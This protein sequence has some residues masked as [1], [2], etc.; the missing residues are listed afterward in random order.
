MRKYGIDCLVR[1][2]QCP[3]GWKR[4]GGSCYFV[5]NQTDT[6]SDANLT[7]KRRQIDHSSLIQIRSAIELVYA[8]HVLIRNNFSSLI[9]TIDP[10]IIKGEERIFSISMGMK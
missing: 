1:R 10:N 2:I 6:P 8:A 3:K 4:L 5:S 9:I 7:C